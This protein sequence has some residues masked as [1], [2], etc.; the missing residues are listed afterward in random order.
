[1]FDIKKAL[2]QLPDS[3]GVYLMKDEKGQII[4]VGKAKVL[5]NRVKQ[6]FQKSGNHTRKILQMIFHIAS[7]EYIVTDTEL[8]AL[9]L[10]CNLIKK[11]SPRYN[12]MLKDDKTYPYIK[13]TVNEDYPKILLVREVYKDGAKYY[14]PYASGY[15]A[16]EVVQLLQKMYKIRNCN[17]V[18]PRD[19]G[20]QRPCLN[21]H[22]KQCDAPCMG[23]V[24]SESYQDR[25]RQAV[26]FLEGDY[27]PIVA[28]LEA[29][30]TAASDGLDFE[31]AG[32][33]RDYIKGIKAIMEK[34]KVAQAS[35]A[36]SDVIAF[37]A[38]DKEAIVQVFFIR[39]G[40]L[41]GREHFRMGNIEGDSDHQIM[42]SFI[43]QFYSGTPFIPKQIIIESAVEEVEIVERWLTEKRGARV[44]IKVPKKGEKNKLVELAKKNAILTLHQFGESIKKEEARTIGAMRQ[45]M[46][47]IQENPTATQ[48]IAAEPVSDYLPESEAEVTFEAEQSD[49]LGVS[50]VEAFDISTHQG[51]ATVGSMVVFENG[52]PKKSDYR[53]FKVKTGVGGDD[54]ASMY[55][56]LTRRFKHALREQKQLI[57]QGASWGEG[58]FSRLPDLILMDG[59]K[60]QVNVAKQVLEEVGLAIPVCGMVKDDH[61]N[62]RGLYYNNV[63]IEIDT[64]SEAFYLI[65]RIQDEAH[66][67]AITYHRATH[68]GIQIKSVLDQIQG[69]GPKRRQALLKQFG[70][71][72]TMKQASLAQLQ[73]VP[74]LDAKTAANVRQFL[75][76]I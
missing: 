39:N 23:Y 61:H 50:R 1:M 6:Y 13:V 17:R 49:K 32:E 16:K 66:R 52:K 31:R 25:I 24:D 75:D 27:Q 4:Y 18:L 47:L 54:Y 53:K 9:I 56:V 38:N 64:H 19:I 7:F 71:I 20:K 29:K 35:Q 58:K 34:Q 59:G 76:K 14:G 74:G 2:Q 8:E 33:Y 11:H 68:K 21:Y 30:M 62:T 69:V 40:K 43:K 12:T 70:S 51:V 67:F 57:E 26:R 65:G 46:Q 22:I 5:K 37:A 42:D 15:H 3:P 41:I 63:E 44:Y 10:E 72:E 36:D 28:E 60:G 48:A 73:A 45:L 55:E